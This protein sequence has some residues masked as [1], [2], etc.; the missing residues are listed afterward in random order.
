MQEREKT[1]DSFLRD[2]FIKASASAAAV[3]PSL[4]RQSFDAVDEMDRNIR[5]GGE[6]HHVIVEI[7]RTRSGDGDLLR[8]GFS[9]GEEFPHPS[10]RLKRLVLRVRAGEK[11]ALDGVRGVAVDVD[12][13][14]VE[15]CRRWSRTG[16]PRNG[17]NRR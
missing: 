3:C 14:Q 16:D 7:S 12:V 13:H 11:S 6:R 4:S 9:A 5:V 10:E 2:P 8:A 1:T 17:Y 15:P